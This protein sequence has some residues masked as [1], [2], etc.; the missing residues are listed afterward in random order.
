M[1]PNFVPTATIFGYPGC[2]RSAEVQAKFAE[3]IDSELHMGMIYADI[4][5]DEPPLCQCA[6]AIVHLLWGS[7]GEVDALDL[8]ANSRATFYMEQA[9]YS[10]LLQLAPGHMFAVA[11]TVLQDATNSKVSH[12]QRNVCLCCL[13]K[14]VVCG[15]C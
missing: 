4:F 13:R 15:S 7:I 10:Q 5:Y 14:Q 9:P 2:E 8:Q 6:E 11:C 3:E 12:I 1:V